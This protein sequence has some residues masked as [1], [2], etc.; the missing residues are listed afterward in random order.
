[1]RANFTCKLATNERVRHIS[2]IL[3]RIF[4]CDFQRL[5]ERTSRGLGARRVSYILRA[6]RKKNKESLGPRQVTDNNSKINDVQLV[7]ICF[8]FGCFQQA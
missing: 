4:R 7:F 8:H 5:R 3:R 6:Y 1:M 2:V